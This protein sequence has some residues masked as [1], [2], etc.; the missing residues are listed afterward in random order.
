VSGRIEPGKAEKDE[1]RSVPRDVPPQPA[2]ASGSRGDR[3]GRLHRHHRALV[4]PQVVRG[5]RCG[6][7]GAQPPPG[8]RAA[9]ARRGLRSQ[10][11]ASVDNR[12]PSTSSSFPRTLATG[13]RCCAR[14]PRTRRPEDAS[15][16]APPR[17][18]S[19]AVRGYRDAATWKA[20]C[21]GSETHQPSCLACRYARDAARP[22]PRT[23]GSASPRLRGRWRERAGA[24]DESGSGDQSAR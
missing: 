10:R 23:R 9:G 17:R 22:S 4:S 24:D 15:H 18:R 11:K 13:R 3:P 8:P 19:A 1:L 7:S 14:W 6:R 16:R 21:G 5:P 2:V 20:R 12:A